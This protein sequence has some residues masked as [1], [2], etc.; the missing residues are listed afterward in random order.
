MV[1][2]EGGR[3]GEECGSILATR[4][5]SLGM[6]EG[7]GACVRRSS[8]ASAAKGTRLSSEVPRPSPAEAGGMAVWPSSG[9]T[10]R[11]PMN[12]TIVVTLYRSAES[13]TCI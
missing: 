2:S 6:R 5:W 8:T 3:V 4:E 1:L 12:S 11:T 9:L 7:G 13:Y 10:E